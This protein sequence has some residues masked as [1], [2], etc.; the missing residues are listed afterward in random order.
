MSWLR[1]GRDPEEFDDAPKPPPPYV[2]ASMRPRA[3]PEFAADPADDDEADGQLQFLASLA[4]EVEREQHQARRQ[5]ASTRFQRRDIELDAD[6][7]LWAFREPAERTDPYEG[8]RRFTGGDVEIDELIDDLA[9]T[10]A[11]LR[12]RRAA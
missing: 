7:A 12:R 9:I 6:D 8:L 3:M 2:P 4:D 10:A 11:A 5:P 1:R